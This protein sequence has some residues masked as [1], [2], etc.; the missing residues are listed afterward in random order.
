MGAAAND[1]CPDSDDHSLAPVK[2]KLFTAYQTAYDG[3]QAPCE[4]KCFDK[5][6]MHKDV[7]NKKG[8]SVT[9]Q[10]LQG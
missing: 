9:S 5:E 1:R 3:Y 2:Y 6:E 7:P 10:S 4:L 8:T